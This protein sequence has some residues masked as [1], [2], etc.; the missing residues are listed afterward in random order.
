MAELDFPYYY[1]KRSIQY[2]KKIYILLILFMFLV[3]VF[4]YF[5]IK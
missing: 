3:P 5:L 4:F 2:K 1:S